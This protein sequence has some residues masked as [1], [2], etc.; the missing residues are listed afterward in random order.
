[1]CVPLLKMIWSPCIQGSFPVSACEEVCCSC[2]E[3]ADI[4]AAIVVRSKLPLASDAVV[5]GLSASIDKAVAGS[6]VSLNV[7]LNLSPLTVHDINV[8]LPS[9]R[10]SDSVSIQIWLV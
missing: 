8:K 5:L 10:Y 1:M 3:P 2:G 6:L 7:G 9:S 4:N